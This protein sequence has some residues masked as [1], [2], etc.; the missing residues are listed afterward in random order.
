[1]DRDGVINR[2]RPNDYVKC[3]SEFEMLPGVPEGLAI[4]AAVFGRIIIV[5]NQQG[6]GK[7]LYTV[8]DPDRIHA[9]MMG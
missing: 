7:G 8:E 2:H 9:W 1:M 3:S 5:T 6:I 4:L